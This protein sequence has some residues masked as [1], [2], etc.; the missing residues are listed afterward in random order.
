MLQWTTAGKG[1]RFALIVHH[2]DSEREF[3]YDKESHVGRL[4]KALDEAKAN[5]WIVVSMKR[6]WKVIYPQKP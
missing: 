2:T 4:D 1:K 6:D 5:E 3:A